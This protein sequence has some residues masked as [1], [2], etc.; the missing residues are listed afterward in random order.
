ME[1]SKEV[2]KSKIDWV[3][4]QNMKIK[5]FLIDMLFV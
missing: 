1:A 2:Q 4:T 5:A 3:A